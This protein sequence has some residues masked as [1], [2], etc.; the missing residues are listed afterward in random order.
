LH[1]ELTRRDLRSLGVAVTVVLID[2]LFPKQGCF[3][4]D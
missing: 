2:L 4:T 3:R 1:L